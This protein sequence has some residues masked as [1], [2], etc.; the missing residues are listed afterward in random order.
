MR[1][2]VQLALVACVLVGRPAFA[3]PP[4]QEQV[5]PLPD[6]MLQ[7]AN[8]HDTDP[9]MAVP[10]HEPSLVVTFDDQA[11]HGWQLVRDQQLQWWDGGKSKALYPLESAPEITVIDPAMAATFQMMTVISPKPDGRSGSAKVVATSI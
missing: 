4:V 1:S 11:M 10:L 8:A 3:A 2:L 6:E 7:A 5:Q 9:F